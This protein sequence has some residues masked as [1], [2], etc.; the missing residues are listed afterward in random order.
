M[1][2]QLENSGDFPNT[3]NLRENLCYIRQLRN[4]NHPIAIFPFALSNFKL[5]TASEKNFPLWRI[6][7]TC[8]HWMRGLAAILVG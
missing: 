8:F 2:E 4:T 7:V 5:K 3:M 1:S 6:S